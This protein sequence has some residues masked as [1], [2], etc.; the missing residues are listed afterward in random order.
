MALPRPGSASNFGLRPWFGLCP[1]TFAGNK[2]DQE[3]YTSVRCTDP[4]DGAKPRT[5]GAARAK[6]AAQRRGRAVAAHPEA[7]PLR[8]TL[9]HKTRTY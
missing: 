1:Q 4:L 3:M 9:F 7:K 5:K 6:E 8:E 2:L